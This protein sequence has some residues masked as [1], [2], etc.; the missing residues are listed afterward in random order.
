A[1][2]PSAGGTTLTLPGTS[3]T[4]S[5]S[6][7]ADSA[8][9]ITD[10]GVLTSPGSTT[11]NLTVQ[12]ASVVGTVQVAGPFNGIGTASIVGSTVTT[13]NLVG[14][15]TLNASTISSNSSL[16]ISVPST[17]V[18]STYNGSIVVDGASLGIGIGS[19]VNITGPSPSIIGNN[20]TGSLTL[21]D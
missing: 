12:N 9:T 13:I 11:P 14:Q 4:A 18:G 3:L 7:S 15:L 5:Q 2:I 21:Q 1:S 10:G 6:V 19:T 8:L 20:S 16:L 17:I